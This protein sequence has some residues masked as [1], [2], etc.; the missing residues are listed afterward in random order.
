MS[1]LKRCSVIALALVAAPLTAAIPDKAA[2]QNHQEPSAKFK[3][4][5]KCSGFLE[6]I[7]PDGQGGLWMLDVEGG[8]ILHAGPGEDC[9]E[10]ARLDGLPAGAKFA[11]DGTITIV[12]RGGIHSFDTKTGKIERISAIYEGEELSGLN[13][14]SYDEQGGF[15]FTA[16]ADSA[17]LAPTGRVFYRSREGEITLVAGGIAYPNGVAVAPDGN[18][19]AVAEFGTNRIISF[20]TVNSKYRL[21][22]PYILA[23]TTGGYGPDGLAYAPD[24]RLLVANFG[25]AAIEIVE[26]RYGGTT[27]FL[28]PEAGTWSTNVAVRDGAIVVVEAEKGDIWQIALPPPRSAPEGAVIVS[29]NQ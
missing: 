20:P 22:F 16:P 21:K 18:Y 23:R 17:A 7:L 15:Y 24:G 26:R 28:P 13:D 8:R 9:V 25:A 2:S 1:L 5:G 29:P 6:G 3:R 10:R 4:I 14:L 11:P 12:G 27:L 19:I